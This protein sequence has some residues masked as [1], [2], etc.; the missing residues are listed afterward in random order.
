VV[1]NYLSNALKFTPSGGAIFV[2]VRAEGSGQYRIEVQDN[3]F[4]IRACDLPRL[5]S[6]FGQLSA[7]EKPQDG[8]GLGLV[9]TK[10]IVEAQGGRVGVESTFGEGS[11]FYAVLPSTRIP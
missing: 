8:T 1:L 6:E 4:G 9:I 10:R 11:R 3:G 7:P 2:E 5:F